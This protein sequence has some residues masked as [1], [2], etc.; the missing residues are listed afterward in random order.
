MRRR[1]RQMAAEAADGDDV[2]RR[3]YDLLQDLI[4]TMLSNEGSM[5]AQP[6]T[7]SK[8]EIRRQILAL[9]D[10]LPPAQREAHSMTI[11]RR[12]LELPEFAAAQT[13]MLFVSFR[14][15]VNTGPLIAAALASG[16]RVCLSRVL[17]R[18][19]MAAFAIDD[20]AIDLVTSSWNIDEPRQ[21][22]PEVAPDELD[23]V[24]IP[25]SVFDLEGGRFGY[26]GGF[27]DTYLLR[28]RR[29][30]VRIAPAF[31]L[32]IVAKLPTDDHDLPIDVIVSERRIL[33]P[34]HAARSSI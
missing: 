7:E 18:R 6:A 12:L 24:V 33:R 23:A 27:Y 26:G 29:D 8:R 21:G 25:G 32:Q 16:R 11:C 19:E 9:R 30:T 17:G 2:E 14:S 28:T 5:S 15:E 31:D 20:P 1:R 10:A 3:R 34:E 13:V 4:R 22:L